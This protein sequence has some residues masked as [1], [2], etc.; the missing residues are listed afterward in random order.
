[1]ERKFD[2]YKQNLSV[3]NFEGADYIKSYDTRVAKI[4]YENSTAEVLGYWSSTTSRHI[5]Y[6]CG[7]LGL[8]KVESKK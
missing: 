3:V 4:D 8:K 6:A 7:M 2:K 1:M 5:S